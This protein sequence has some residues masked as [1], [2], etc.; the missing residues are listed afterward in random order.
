MAAKKELIP[1]GSV[2]KS[3][4][5][6]GGIVISSDDGEWTVLVPRKSGGWETKYLN[7][8][9]MVDID[10]RKTTI[11]ASLKT[12]HSLANKTNCLVALHLKSGNKEKF[13]WTEPC[14]Y[15]LRYFNK[16]ITE[17]REYIA[18]HIEGTRNAKNVDEKYKDTNMTYGQAHKDW[19]EWMLKHSGFKDVFKTKTYYHAMKY[20]IT[21]DVTQGVNK[22]AAAVVALRFINEFCSAGAGKGRTYAM[23]REHGLDVPQAFI[24]SKLL[25]ES[26]KLWVYSSAYGGHC[27]LNSSAISMKAFVNAMYFGMKQGTGVPLSE[28]VSYTIFNAIDEDYPVYRNNKTIDGVLRDAINKPIPG[29]K[30]E[31]GNPRVGATTA[32]EAF[33][34]LR[35]LVESTVEQLKKG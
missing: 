6:K 24:A 7:L 2:L 8:P 12:L 18:H 10:S 29:K 13:S 14:H 9:K 22:V 20:G 31:W 26:N 35:L 33:D 3:G 1:V 16:G 28:K 27:I 34:T 11:A 15:V 19:V 25:C 32:K 4:D 23:A 21:I 30:D 5:F 17:Y